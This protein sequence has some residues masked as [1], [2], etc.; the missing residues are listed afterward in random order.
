MYAD[1]DVLVA[2]VLFGGGM[3]DTEM[4]DSNPAPG[5]SKIRSYGNKIDFQEG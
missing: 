3:V 5:T 2:R 1:V 4:D